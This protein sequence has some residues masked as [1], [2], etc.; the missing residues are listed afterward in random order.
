MNRKPTMDSVIC[1]GCIYRN[2]RNDDGK[3]IS[4]NCELVKEWV[5]LLSTNK[6][7][8]KNYDVK[9]LNAFYSPCIRK[10]RWPYNIVKKIIIWELEN[11]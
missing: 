6:Q 7:Y 11:L 5:G 1:K 9:L 2:D 10:E 4:P 8:M 3:L